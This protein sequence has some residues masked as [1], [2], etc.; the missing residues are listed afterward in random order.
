MENNEVL[1]EFIGFDILSNGYYQFEGEV[2]R[3]LPDFKISWD[4]LMKVVHKCLEICNENML[5]EWEAG[6]S[7]AFLSADI[8]QMYQEAVEFIEFYKKNL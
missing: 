2:T 5:N 7:D 3:S 8:I 1:A 4:W 6:F